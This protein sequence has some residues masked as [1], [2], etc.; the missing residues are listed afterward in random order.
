[1]VDW[2]L[3]YTLIKEHDFTKLIILS[4]HSKLY[5]L[6]SFLFFF[7]NVVSSLI[8]LTFLHFLTGSWGVSIIRQTW[9]NRRFTFH[10][11]TCTHMHRRAWASSAIDWAFLRHT[12]CHEM[13]R[14]PHNTGCEDEKISEEKA[15]TKKHKSFPLPLVMKNF[16][17]AS[18][19]QGNYFSILINTAAVC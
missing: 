19:K 4:L 1:M 11:H 13:G 6:Y 9:Q 16:C 14:I 5:F 15:A 18:G 10:T 3:S 12:I 7:F 8:F 17:T 2:F